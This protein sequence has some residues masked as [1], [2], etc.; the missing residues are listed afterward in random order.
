MSSSFHWTI[1]PWGQVSYYLHTFVYSQDPKLLN[2]TQSRCSQPL[3]GNK[4]LNEWIFTLSLSYIPTRVSLLLLGRYI[5]FLFVDISAL[6]CSGN[7]WLDDLQVVLQGS[8]YEERT[9]FCLGSKG[10]LCIAGVHGNSMRDKAQLR[11]CDDTSSLVLS[12][13]MVVFIFTDDGLMHLTWSCPCT[14]YIWSNVHD[15]TFVSWCGFLAYSTGL[16]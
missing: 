14:A 6:T 10:P 11:L 5:F 15:L 7:L 13:C 3:I 16:N 1:S 4:W 8:R 12:L 9:F 2:L